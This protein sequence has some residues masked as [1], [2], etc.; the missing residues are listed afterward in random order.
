MGLGQKFEE[1]EGMKKPSLKGERKSV[2]ETQ[3]DCQE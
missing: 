3:W 1:R 2:T